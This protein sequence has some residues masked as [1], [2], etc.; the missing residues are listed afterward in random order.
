MTVE[1]MQVKGRTGQVAFD[2]VF[3]TITRQGFAARTTVGKSDKRIP[4]GSITAVHWKPAGALANG[5]IQFTVP[6]G[7]ERRSGLGHQTTGAAQ[8][9]NSVGFTKGQ[10]RAFAE[11]RVAVEKAVT[12]AQTPRQVAQ[13]ASA[14][15]A[16]LASW[17]SCIW[18]VS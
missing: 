5:F 15:P 4:I 17:P 1:P 8:D 9:E 13:P 16:D 7:N 11:L 10:M 18:P 12:G 3:V 14:P 2:G 6:G